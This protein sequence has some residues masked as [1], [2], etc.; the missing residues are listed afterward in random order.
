MNRTPVRKCVG[1]GAR[2]SQVDLLR[3]VKNNDQLHVDPRGNLPGRG[4]YICPNRQ[5][6]KAARKQGSLASALKTTVPEEFYNELME[7]IGNE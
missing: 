3:I 2:R 4:V 1:C 7:E 6:L 5:C